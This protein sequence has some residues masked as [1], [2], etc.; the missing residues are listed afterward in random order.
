LERLFRHARNSPPWVD[1]IITIFCDFLQFSTKNGVFLKN[2]CY[3]QILAKT[4]N[5]LS[6]KRQYIFLPKKLVKIFLKS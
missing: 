2:Q 5:S 6:K 3:D 1:V 4:S